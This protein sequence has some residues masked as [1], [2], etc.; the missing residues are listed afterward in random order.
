M[1][2]IETAIQDAHKARWLPAR[3]VG[4]MSWKFE[5]RDTPFGERWWCEN[6]IGGKYFFNVNDAFIDPAF[7]SALDKARGWKKYNLSE[8]DACGSALDGWRAYWH[9]FIDHLIS[10]GDA[11]T[12][13]ANL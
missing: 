1:T 10:G 4:Q 7:W 9:R 5:L 8:C 12:F 3:L 6:D 2:A 11:E 13:F